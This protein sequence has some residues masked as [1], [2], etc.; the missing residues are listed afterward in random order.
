M[1]FASSDD[2]ASEEILVAGRALPIGFNSLGTSYKSG[3]QREAGAI[4]WVATGDGRIQV[5]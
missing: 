2:H 1:V 3:K 5:R 4:L